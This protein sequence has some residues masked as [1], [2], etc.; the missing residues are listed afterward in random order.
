MRNP[1]ELFFVILRLSS[2]AVLFALLLLGAVAYWRHRTNP[3]IKFG[4][5]ALLV[6]GVQGFVVAILYTFWS[7]TTPERTVAGAV[8]VS[9]IHILTVLEYGL[10]IFFLLHMLGYLGGEGPSRGADG[11][12][13]G[14]P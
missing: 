12:S 13:E 8:I 5:A 11:L 1:V 6:S 7:L 2:A 10:L 9:S 3:I 4:G 14:K